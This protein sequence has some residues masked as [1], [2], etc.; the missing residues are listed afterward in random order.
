MS[1]SC[2]FLVFSSS[3]L[4]LC[5]SIQLLLSLSHSFTLCLFNIILTLPLSLSMSHSTT[6]TITSSFSLSGNYHRLL[7]RAQQ[8]LLLFLALMATQLGVSSRF[9]IMTDSLSR[10]LSLSL[11][12]SH[13]H[14]HSL[15]FSFFLPLSLSSFHNE[16]ESSFR[17]WKENRTKKFQE[18][19][20]ENQTFG[21]EQ[22]IKNV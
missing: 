3:S 8:A 12:L 14:T 22:K 2:L 6:H 1:F 7:G 18:K 16:K 10:T 4:S 17:T 15:P 9:D 19:K 21:F 20:I 5:I 11:T 13:T